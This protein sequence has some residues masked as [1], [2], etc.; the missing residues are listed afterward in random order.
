MEL[1]QEHYTNTHATSTRPAHTLSA[2]REHI[3]LHETHTKRQTNSITIHSAAISIS[4]CPQQHIKTQTHENT[5]PY[6]RQSNP[7]AT[8]SATRSACICT[9]HHTKTET[10]E[11]TSSI[12]PAHTHIETAPLP[13][14][15]TVEWQQVYE[16]LD[17]AQQRPILPWHI[18]DNHKPSK[19]KI[20]TKIIPSPLT[21]ADEI[22]EV[23]IN[24]L[25]QT[26]ETR[27]RQMS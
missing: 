10:Q 1:S 25:L 11:N 9:K 18:T 13:P 19:K 24:A 23:A 14:D 3:T 16:T 22:C 4:T 12:S 5:S 21:M 7:I 27:W 17:V 15:L 26:P 2:E 20:H 6:T 8:L